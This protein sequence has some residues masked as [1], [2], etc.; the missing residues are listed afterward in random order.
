VDAPS[1]YLRV[2]GVYVVN[3][4]YNYSGS[5]TFPTQTFGAT[6]YWVDVVYI[7]AS[8]MPGAPPAVL[9][10]PSTLS[11]VAFAT[12]NPPPAQTISVYNE[13]DGALPWTASSS[14]PWL[15]AS[16]AS[17]STPSS[18]PL[19]GDTSGLDRKSVV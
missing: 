9:V 14:A 4:V 13:G 11:F 10:N 17:G 19:S 5:S 16:P 18:S 7:P 8:S 15:I 3:G 1:M 2:I 12:G 6:N